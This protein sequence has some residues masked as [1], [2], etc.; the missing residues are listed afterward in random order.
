MLHP[1]IISAPFGNYFNRAGVTSTVGT[2]T[3]HSRRTDQ[4]THGEYCPSDEYLWWLGMLFQA[5]KTIRYKR[6]LGGWVNRMGLRN[7]GRFK[8]QSLGNKGLLH[9]KLISIRG[10]N[11]REWQILLRLLF[12][13]H[14]G[15]IEFNFSCPNCHELSTSILDA[16]AQLLVWKEMTSHPSSIDLVPVFAK[17]PPV[18]TC[19]WARS[20]I[21]AYPKLGLHCSNTIPC[22]HG[23]LSG[24]EVFAVNAQSIKQI[25]REHPHTP[26][27]AGGGVHHF[28]QLKQ[29]CDLGV[30][31]VAVASMLFNPCNWRKLEQFRNHLAA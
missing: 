3:W 28:D 8:I 9:D 27:I 19:R 11:D 20:L 6:K 16:Q 24:R 4:I 22:E 17:I 26:I 18:D 10:M 2:F 12:S 5:A 1:L 25:R 29:Y 30:Q 14:I 23:G 13:Y 7:P 15:G 31:H 21:A